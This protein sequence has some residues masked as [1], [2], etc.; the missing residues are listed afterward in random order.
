MK[1]AIRER[2][3]ELGFD[4]CRFTTALVPESAPQFQQWLREQRHGEMAYLQRN[5]HKR[6]DPQKVLPGAESV[7]TLATSYEEKAAGRGRK[8]DER[9]LTPTLSPLSAPAW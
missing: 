5:A 1:E 4:D 2:A 9:P 7:I 3:R 8:Q 6:V